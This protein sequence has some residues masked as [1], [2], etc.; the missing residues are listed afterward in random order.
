MKFLF[1]LILI[2]S[3]NSRFISGNGFSGYIFDENHEVMF[4]AG[5]SNK[6]YTPSDKDIH[7]A[8]DILKR[9]IKSA[10]RELLNQNGG[11]PVIHENLDKYIRQY[12]GFINAKGEKVIYINFVWSKTDYD[13]GNDIILVL[14]GCSNYWN[15]KVNLKKGSLSDLNVNGSA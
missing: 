4:S 10:N 11:C 3:Y 9:Q 8:E 6:R 1:C 5:D 7:L 13:F 15:V 12:V 2:I 14:D